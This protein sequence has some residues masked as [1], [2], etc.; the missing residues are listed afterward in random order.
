V[1]ELDVGVWPEVAA[2]YAAADHALEPLSTTIG[3]NPFGIRSSTYGSASASFSTGRITWG[4]ASY[5]PSAA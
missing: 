4:H 5:G 2:L 3:S 1:G